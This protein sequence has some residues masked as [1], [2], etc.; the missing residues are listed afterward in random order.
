LHLRGIQ[1]GGDFDSL[2]QP[3]VGALAGVP[4]EAARVV[5]PAGPSWEPAWASG[6]AAPAGPAARLRQPRAP[7]LPVAPITLAVLAVLWTRPVHHE[8]KARKRGR[9]DEY[10]PSEDTVSP[11]PLAPCR[12]TGGQPPEQGRRR[13]HHVCRVDVVCLHPCH[14]VH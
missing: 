5:A 3:L 11:R 12:R 6:P 10:R 14:L 7:P 2:I 4:A 9:S 1:D 8:R 13:D